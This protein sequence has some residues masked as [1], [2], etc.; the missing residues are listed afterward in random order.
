MGQ[1]KELDARFCRAIDDSTEGL[2]GVMHE[3]L[4]WRRFDDPGLI[5]GLTSLCWDLVVINDIGSENDFGKESRQLY[6]CR[7]RSL[8]TS[9]EGES[10]DC[11]ISIVRLAMVQR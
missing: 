3:D 10:R 7:N 9:L 4:R 1:V 6:A 8:I 2:Q 11:Y 5:L